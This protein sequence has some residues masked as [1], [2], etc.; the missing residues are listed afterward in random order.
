[1]S[2]SNNIFKSPV[3]TFMGH[4]DAGKTSLQDIICENN[5]LEDGNITQNIKVRYID[6][7]KINKLSQSI[8]GKFSID[9]RLPGVMVIDTPGH[10]AFKNM[11]SMG[12][13]I[14][15]LAV[16]VID[17]M[18]GVKPQ[19]IESINILKENKIPFVIALN[20]LDLIDGWVNSDELSLRKA[21]KKNI[22][23]NNMILS[24]IE[25]IKWELNKINIESEFYF[26]NKKPQSIYSIIPLSSK[27]GEGIADLFGMISYLTFN[28][29]SKKVKFNN[30]TKASVIKSYL[31]P[32][33]GHCL[34]IILSNGYLSIGDSFYIINYEKPIISKIKNI[35]IFENNKWKQTNQT[36]ASV[37]CKIIGTNME[38]IITGTLMYPISNDQE[39]AF[40]KAQKNMKNLWEQ[41]QYDDNGCILLAPSFGKLSGCYY[42]FNKEKIK[43]KKC[44]LGNLTETLLDKINILLDKEV[45]VLY[46]FGSYDEEKIN[47]IIKNNNYNFTI[48]S[49]T[50]LFSM[51]DQ[52]K[53]FNEKCQ[54]NIVEKLLSEGKINY[55]V[56][57]EIVPNCVFNMG[58]NSE[59]LIGL[60]IIE[61]KLLKNTNI[62]VNNGSSLVNLGNVVS[63]EKDKEQIDK[64]RV[65][66]KIAVKLSN[67]ENKLFKRHFQEENIMVSYL[68]REII[69]NLKK[70]YRDKL[71]KK[72]WLLVKELKLLFLK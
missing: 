46:Y 53:D 27:T 28:W 9:Q 62:Y 31:D 63:M 29:M 2:D 50:I 36:K 3:I 21:I 17:I 42:Q 15:D 72:E 64:G 22:K 54:Q 60:K 24:N 33:M 25:D 16:I 65:G 11:R 10:E 32:K 52:A 43:I 5:S 47:K 20:K 38:N 6:N 14:C 45:K 35:F 68:S 58:G 71:T 55:P 66:D 37:Y 34:E 56:K 1:M 49:N 67:N 18:S 23:T 57:C 26:N 41:F 39:S 70:Y 19:T 8:K 51:I 40:N 13:N 48:I 4:V 61:G 30:I 69:D 12:S 59:I 44:L 7:S